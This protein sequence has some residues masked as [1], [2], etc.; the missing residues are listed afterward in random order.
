MR[1]ATLAALCAVAALGCGVKKELYAAKEFEAN[2]LKQQLQDQTGRAAALEAKVA[3]LERRLAATSVARADLEI[4]TARLVEEKSELEAKSSEYEQLTRSLQTQIAA[5]DVELSELKG[6]MTVKLRDRVLFPFGSARITRE[7]Q[8]ALD[9]VASALQGLRGKNVIVAGYT[10]DVGV[11][12]RAS[13][14]DNWE[15]STMRALAV[16]R[17][18]QSRGV[19]PRMLGAA[20]FSEYRPLVPNDTEEGRSRNRRIEIALT[21]ADYTPPEVDVKR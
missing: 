3:D 7:G 14:A 1:D 8:V 13:Y 10:D 12:R 9:A 2:Q 15:L 5:G 18:L 11:S 17:H 6:R 20:G 21:P 19:D 4:R 16:V